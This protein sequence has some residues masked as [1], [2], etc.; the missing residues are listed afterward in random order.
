MKCLI[1]IF[2]ILLSGC[3]SIDTSRITFSINPLSYLSAIEWLR[4][5]RYI[6]PEERTILDYKEFSKPV[7]KCFYC[8]KEKWKFIEVREYNINNDVVLEEEVAGRI[9]PLLD[10]WVWECLKC[11]Y[12][13]DPKD[14]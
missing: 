4:P 12:V 5:Y 9:K 10:Y 14:R 11:G 6:S 7:G 2:C 8:G 1:L 3:A 13:P